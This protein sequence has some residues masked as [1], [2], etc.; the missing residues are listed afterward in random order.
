MS[1]HVRPKTIKTFDLKLIKYVVHLFQGTVLA[2]NSGNTFASP[3]TDRQ[4]NKLHVAEKSPVVLFNSEVLFFFLFLSDYPSVVQSL[5][6]NGVRSHETKVYLKLVR[7][8]LK[9]F[10]LGCTRRNVQHL[11]FF[12]I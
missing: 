3:S 2:P 10:H 9:L 7:F 4:T 6:G 11:S 1:G 5:F 12:F 8:A